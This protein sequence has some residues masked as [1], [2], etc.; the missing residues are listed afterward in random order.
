MTGYVEGNLTDPDG[1][2]E[3]LA[4]AAQSIPVAAAAR[5]ARGSTCTAPGSTTGGLPVAAGRGGHRRDVAGRGRTPWAGSRRW[6]SARASSSCW[7][8][9]TPPSTTPVRRSRKAADTL[10]LVEAVDSPHLS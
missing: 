10:A 2:D 9:S 6:A 3:L 8:T 4:T 1:A 5:H 7:R